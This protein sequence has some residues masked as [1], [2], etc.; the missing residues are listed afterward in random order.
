MLHLATGASIATVALLWISAYSAH[1]PPE[2]HGWLDVL[3]LCFPIFAAG[4][5]AALLGWLIM[6]SKRAILPLAGFVCCISDVQAYCPV[7]IPQPAPKGC[8]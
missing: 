8:L 1:I 7:N 3:G 6:R 4:N 2:K 5:A